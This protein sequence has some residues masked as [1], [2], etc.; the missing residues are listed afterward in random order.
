MFFAIITICFHISI[1]EA[2]ESTVVAGSGKT[3]AFGIPMIHTILEWRNSSAKPVDDKTK[4]TTQVESL[5]LP[6]SS[7][8]GE[9]TIEEDEVD[10]MDAEEEEDEG[11]TEQDQ[12]N[13][14]EHD[15]EDEYDAEEQDDSQRLGCVQVIDNAEFDFDQTAEA[16]EKPAGGRVQPL[17]GLVLTPTR[18]LAVQVKHH[19][20]AVAKF[21]GK[22]LKFEEL[23]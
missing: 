19:I 20:D 17:L 3:L 22:S 15:S 7:K 12:G 16:G 2:N 5:Y 23:T 8:S 21:T 6:E 13:E 9:S 11:I 4:A 14:D 10:N 18:E 1:S